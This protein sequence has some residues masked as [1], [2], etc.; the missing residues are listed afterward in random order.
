VDES[1]RAAGTVELKASGLQKGKRV[2]GVKRGKGVDK[3]K[4]PKRS[5]REKGMKLKNKT[6]S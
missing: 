6:Q 1:E 2:Y 5:P 4:G 3:R